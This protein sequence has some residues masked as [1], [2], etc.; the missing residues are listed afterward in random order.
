MTL[1]HTPRS[2]WA[3]A[4]FHQVSVTLALL[5]PPVVPVVPDP[6]VP[7]DPLL[8]HAATAVAV[9]TATAMAASARLLRMV[10]H[11]PELFESFSITFE[12]SLS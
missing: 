8:L 2:G 5:E 11:L 12:V 10:G 4:L 7:A 1:C 3:V 9:V 6:L